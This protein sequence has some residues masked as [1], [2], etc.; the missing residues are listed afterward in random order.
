MTL[1]GRIRVRVCTRD[2][3]AAKVGKYGLRCSVDDDGY[4][5]RV[6]GTTAAVEPGVAY[7]FSAWVKSS[8]QVRIGYGMNSGNQTAGTLVD[9][10]GQWVRVAITTP[11]MPAGTS[12][13]A[14]WI[15]VADGAAVGTQF[16]VDGVMVTSGSTQYGFADGNSADWTWQGAMNNS[17]SSGPASSAL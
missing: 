9:S 8:G 15:G 4:F 3:A 2:A 11:V 10:S 1:V 7:T 16:D 6:V 14:P 12:T 13:A 17:A 5:P